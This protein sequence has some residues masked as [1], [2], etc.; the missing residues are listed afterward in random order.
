MTELDALQRALARLHEAVYGYGLAG[1]HL[2]RALRPVA[3]ARLRETQLLRDAVA[4]Q[5]RRAG[6]TPTPAA[7]AYAPPAPVVDQASA[8]DLLVSIESAASGAAWDLVAASGPD[9]TSRRLAVGWLSAAAR[10]AFEWR[11]AA[12]FTGGEPS[13]PPVRPRPS[14]SAGLTPAVDDAD[15]LREFLDHRVGLDVVGGHHVVA[16]PH[17][18]HARLLRAGN[19]VVQPVTDEHRP[20]RLHAD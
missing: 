19:V 18:A 7:M 3:A 10:A 17:T 9:T 5:V 20:V 4:A 1:P 15:D 11:G 12:A 2:S 6:A 13:V 16:H 14:G 8:V